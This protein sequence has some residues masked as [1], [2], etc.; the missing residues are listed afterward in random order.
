MAQGHGIPFGEEHPTFFN[1]YRRKREHTKGTACFKVKCVAGDGGGTEG[2]VKA[3][4][5]LSFN[6]NPLVASVRLPAERRES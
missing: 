2:T 5:G 3:A 6:K 4:T 1:R